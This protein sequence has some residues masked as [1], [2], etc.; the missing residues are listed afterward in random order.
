[1]YF[2]KFCA[3]PKISFQQGGFGFSLALHDSCGNNWP[4]GLCTVYH[5]SHFV[6]WFLIGRSL[7]NNISDW[8][9]L[10][11]LRLLT[12]TFYI[13]TSEVSTFSRQINPILNQIVYFYAD[14]FERDWNRV[15][16]GED[17]GQRELSPLYW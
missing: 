15:M 5:H 9:S 10:L 6:T 2:R 4:A 14:S 17:L 1:M 12:I 3:V 8:T 7:C 13:V 16:A 11:Y